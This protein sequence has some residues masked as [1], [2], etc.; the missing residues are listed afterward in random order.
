MKTKFFYPT[1]LFLPLFFLFLSLVAYGQEQWEICGERNIS[2]ATVAYTVMKANAA[3]TLHVLFNDSQYEN[4]ATVMAFDG[5]NWNVV[6]TPGFTSGGVTQRADIAFD[7]AGNVWVVATLGLN[8]ADNLEVWKFDGSSWTSVGPTVERAGIEPKIEYFN[9]DIYIGLSERI[10]F[11]N[12]I[13][14]RKYDNGAWNYVG[15]PHLV[16]GFG[17]PGQIAF[18]G[19]EPYISYLVFMTGNV[20]PANV[21]KYNGSS[22]VQVGAPNF[23]LGGTARNAWGQDIEF[24]ASGTLYM[25]YYDD[26]INNSLNVWKFEGGS[27]Q[28][29]GA[30]NFTRCFWQ[31]MEF[32]G[33]TPYVGFQDLVNGG[34]S[35]MTFNGTSWEYV[36]GP[37]VTPSSAYTESLE[38]HNGVIAMAFTDAGFVNGTSNGASVIKLGAVSAPDQDQDGIPDDQDNCPSIAN[39]DQLDT[40]QDGEGDVCDTDDDNDGC[41]DEDDANPLVAS[42]DTDEDGVADDCDICPNDPDDD[43]DGDGICGDLD[44]CP[45]EANADQLDTDQDGEGDVCDPDDDND[46]CL[47]EDDE[48]PLVAS[49]DSDQDGT[50]DDCDIC[51]NDPDDDI[52]GD[53]ICGDVD[54]CPTEA[55]AD[56][57]DTDQ[58]GEGDICDPD[59][60]NDGCLDEDDANPLV[61]SADSD[62]DGVG[63]DCDVCPGGDDSVDN[64][65]DGIPDCSQLLDYDDYADEWKCGKKKILVCHNG[66]NPH[67][68]C[69]NINALPAHLAHGDFIGGCT[70]C[71]SSDDGLVINNG[72]ERIGEMEVSPNPA[73]SEVNVRFPEVATNGQLIVR[74]QLGRILLS[75]TLELG[76]S[77]T[78]VDVRTNRFQNGIYFISLLIDGE[79]TTRKVMIVK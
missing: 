8:D 70:S 38:I 59:D 66:N 44:N 76:T 22:W 2:G 78:I 63:D 51:P 75:Q 57:L 7:A 42:I 48:Y 47:D 25:A 30:P 64:N 5:S 21:K 27:W 32:D 26:G 24:S 62:C 19:G 74:D 52:D 23:S 71:S 14:M 36:G 73:S 17:W 34:G 4:K 67:T 9:G 31:D 41:L 28:R 56:Q 13:S 39:A 12:G 40:D 69:I 53:G 77:N 16:S 3:G 72:Q 33:D 55:N 20:A 54:N 6:G 29:V 49:V 10:N 45:L 58:D 43:I 60:D 61:A 11:Q 18:N 1:K 79:Q 46:G 15:T 35:V 37:R 50:A 65:G 68:I